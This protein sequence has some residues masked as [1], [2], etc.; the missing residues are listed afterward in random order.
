MGVLGDLNCET[1]GA[2]LS[3]LTGCVQ[4]TSTDFMPAG[5]NLQDPVFEGSRI[6]AMNSICLLADDCCPLTTPLKISNMSERNGFL[7]TAN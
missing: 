7:E 2:I 3:L 6:E 5:L 4:T 1:E